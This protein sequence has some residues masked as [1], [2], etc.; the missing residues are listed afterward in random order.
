MIWKP[1]SK[2]H[3]VYNLPKYHNRSKINYDKFFNLLKMCPKII[4]YIDYRLLKM[5]RPCNISSN[6]ISFH[7][8]HQIYKRSGRA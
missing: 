1:E 7:I 8:F 4:K 2:I 5:N 6:I 3:A